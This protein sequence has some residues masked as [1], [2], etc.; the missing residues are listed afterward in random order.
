MYDQ[1]INEAI[2]LVIMVV[3]VVI[4][5][6]VIPWVKANIDLKQLALIQS[7]AISVVEAAEMLFKHGDNDSKLEYATS[8]L[9]QMLE[10][11]GIKLSPTE[12]RNCVEEA[13]LD[14]KK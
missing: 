6:Y 1:I 12:L 9:S 10:K 13:V 8:L 7:Y 5:R 2:K 11:V 3:V 4:G 14:L